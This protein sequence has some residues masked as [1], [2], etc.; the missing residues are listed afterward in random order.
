MNVKNMVF[1]GFLLAG[2]IL[3]MGLK[4]EINPKWEYGHLWYS[5]FEDTLFKSTLPDDESWA[6]GSY[7]FFWRDGSERIAHLFLQDKKEIWTTGISDEDL[8]EKSVLNKHSSDKFLK[9]IGLSEDE[10]RGITLLIMIM[11]S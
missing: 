6:I 7:K 2:V 4:G 8:E 10:I 5:S 3:L 1:V 9:I 11:G